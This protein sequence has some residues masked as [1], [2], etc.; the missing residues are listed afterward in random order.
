M[1]KI[2][3]RGFTLIELLAVITIMGIL[4]IVAIPAVTRT[5][6]N[7]RKD[8]FIDTVK[9]YVNGAKIMWTSD[10]LAC[11]ADG[12]VSSAVAAGWYYVEVNSA[13]ESVP[14]LLESGGK[15]PW[16]S[17]DMVGFILIHVYDELLDV[18]PDGVKNG[19]K[20]CDGSFKPGTTGPYACISYDDEV[21][22]NLDYYPAI[23]DGIHSSAK[24]IGPGYNITNRI[25]YGTIEK[26][27][28][29][30]RGD[31]VMSGASYKYVHN[32]AGTSIDDPTAV[33]IIT[34]CYDVNNLNACNPKNRAVKCVEA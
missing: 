26:V 22:R 33:N 5:I 25:P 15:S 10:N 29:I 31:L 19:E 7:A 20:S 23:T 14:Q 30:T 13:S 28:N 17:R 32:V 11:G 21:I 16:G 3:S 9:Q 2:N 34:P 27:E 12:L 6:E 8:T 24:A 1:K 4:M 18:G